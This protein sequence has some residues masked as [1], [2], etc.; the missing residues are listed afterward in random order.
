MKKKEINLLLPWR[1]NFLGYFPG[2]IGAG[3]VPCDGKGD[4]G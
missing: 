4:M 1:P 2:L 3:I